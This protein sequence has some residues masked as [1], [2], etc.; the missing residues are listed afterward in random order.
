MATMAMESQ[1]GGY[2]VRV[3]VPYPDRLNNFLPIVKL[4]LAIPHFIILG[5][6][7]YVMIVTWFITFFAILFTGRYPAG[8]FKF[9]VGI[10][11]W[12]I[13]TSSYAWLLRD[14]YPPFGF[15]EGRYP[16]VLQVEY[17]ENLNRWMV[18]IKWLLGIPHYIIVY[19]LTLIG[20]VLW[21][22]SF[23][24]I[25]FTGKHPSG[26]FNYHVG[27]LRWNERMMQYFLLVTDKYPPFSFD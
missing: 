12:Q 10:R 13:N 1:P 19:I 17:P 22:I 27:R 26:L 18:L 20:Y 23:F 2:P 21:I 24:A 15:E 6:L 9:H 3:E 14:E 25:L 7:Q 16:A 5:I 11:R 8:L 4:I